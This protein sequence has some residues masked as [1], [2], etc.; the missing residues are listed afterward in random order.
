MGIKIVARGVETSWPG[1]GR[2]A[3]K[4]HP[5]FLRGAPC[6]ATV[7]GYTAANYIFPS[8]LAPSMAREDMI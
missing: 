6:L 4:S 7:T 2:L 8:V 5:C 1:R 3:S